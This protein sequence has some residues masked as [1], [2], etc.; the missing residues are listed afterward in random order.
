MHTDLC[1]WFQTNLSEK[2][3][4]FSRFATL[5]I[6]RTLVH[7][8]FKKTSIAKAIIK[9][10]NKQTSFNKLFRVIQR[11]FYMHIDTN[12]IIPVLGSKRSR[13]RDKLLVQTSKTFPQNYIVRMIQSF[14]LI[15]FFSI[16]RQFIC[17]RCIDSF[18]LSNVNLDSYGP[19]R[20]LFGSTANLRC[21]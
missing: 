5:R 19:K 6:S 9:Q 21:A 8:L 7:S 11:N 17:V 13:L 16:L 2:I 3:Q 10:T 14:V 15:N 12:I 4:T 20:S 18:Y 1:L